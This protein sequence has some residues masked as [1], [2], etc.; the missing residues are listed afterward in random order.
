ML[1]T[2]LTSEH[3]CSSNPSILSARQLNKGHFCVKPRSR[4]IAFTSLYVC[5]SSHEGF[6]FPV[7]ESRFRMD[8]VF[9]QFLQTIQC[10]QS[11]VLRVVLYERCFQLS[12]GAAGHSCLVALRSSGS[13]VIVSRGFVVVSCV[14]GGLC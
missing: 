11:L 1:Q 4:Q 2:F 6:P 3:A 10:L 7:D 13:A 14:L 12:R 5:S 8:L 9:S